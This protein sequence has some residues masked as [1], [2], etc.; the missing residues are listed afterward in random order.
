MRVIKISHGPNQ[1]K[2]INLA[3][4]SKNVNS[5]NAKG[6]YGISGRIQEIEQMLSACQKL[7]HWHDTDFNNGTLKF[8]H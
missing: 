8:G 7:M 5:Y 6:N 3:N 4:T 1:I 2:P